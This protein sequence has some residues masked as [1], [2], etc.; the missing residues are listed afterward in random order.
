MENSRQRLCSLQRFPHLYISRASLDLQLRAPRTCANSF[1]PTSPITTADSTTCLQDTHRPASSDFQESCATEVSLSSDTNS[2]ILTLI[3]YEFVAADITDIRVS[4]LT[5][6]PFILGSEER[7]V[8][9]QRE[10]YSHGV[11]TD[12][13]ISV[14]IRGAKSPAGLRPREIASKPARKTTMAQHPLL[15]TCRQLQREFVSV[16]ESCPCSEHD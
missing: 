9:E 8:L 15:H 11:V 3:V 16:C 13:I 6:V 5:K 2:K 12:E 7:V 1:L 14:Y 10:W 4:P